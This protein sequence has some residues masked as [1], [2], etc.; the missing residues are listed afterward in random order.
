MGKTWD[1]YKNAPNLQLQVTER[2]LNNIDNTIKKSGL[3]VN[4]LNRWIGWNAGPGSLQRYAQSKPISSSVIK[5]NLPKGMAPTTENYINYWSKK[6][7]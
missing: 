1:D 4:N 2:Y 3:P 7:G 6:W 5:W